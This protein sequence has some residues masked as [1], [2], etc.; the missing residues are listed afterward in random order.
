MKK[1]VRLW[2]VVMGIF[3][4]AGCTGNLPNE[5]KAKQVFEKNNKDWIEKGLLHIDS[6][7]KTNGQKQS[8][9]GYEVYILDYEAIV[10]FPKGTNAPC[11]NWGADEN[12]FF[13]CFMSNSEN[14]SPSGQPAK[15]KGKIDFEKTEKGWRSGDQVY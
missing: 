7:K 5:A 12:R 4:L 9:P 8:I 15:V 6:F 11:I 1:H 10:S 13:Q 2:G 3:A 14:V